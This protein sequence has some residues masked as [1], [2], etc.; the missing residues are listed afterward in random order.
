MKFTEKEKKYL[1]SAI[2]SRMDIMR[3]VINN[4]KELHSNKHYQK[5][6]SLIAKINFTESIS[7]IY[8]SILTGIVREKY[9]YEV[10]E[11]KE[12]YYN[13]TDLEILK[14]NEKEK[15]EIEFI[16]EIQVLLNK[17]L[18]KDKR[19]VLLEEYLKPYNELKKLP[20]EKSFYSI[21]GEKIYKI[22]I[23]IDEKKLINIELDVNY[24]IFPFSKN[25]ILNWKRMFMFTGKNDDIINLFKHY[26]K[27]NK[28]TER[29]KF[30]LE[31]LKKENK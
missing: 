15:S 2:E 29:M 24:K 20:Y 27:E 17:I 28:L 26:S 10:E 3:K 14:I 23:Q 13:K 4:E 9:Y 12:F 11:R 5:V 22:G 16:T 18:P 1:I 31:V 30:A 21:S 8:K 7:G 19:E 6:K 25:E